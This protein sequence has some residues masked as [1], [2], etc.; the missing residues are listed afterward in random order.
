MRK[1][2]HCPYCSKPL[3]R[4]WLRTELNRDAGRARS[5]AKTAA[6]RKAAVARWR[7]VRKSKETSS[8]PSVI[9]PAVG[10]A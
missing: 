2:L 4:K 6:A 7:A 10:A 5:P 9:A 8:S 3:P 1:F